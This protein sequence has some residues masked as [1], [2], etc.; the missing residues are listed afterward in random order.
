MVSIQERFLIKMGYSGARTV[1][2]MERTLV[3][4]YQITKYVLHPMKRLLYCLDVLHPMKR[5]LYCLDKIP[6]I[7][8]AQKS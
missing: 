6:N 2:K 7:F 4:K 5:L 8:Y 1:T 3:N